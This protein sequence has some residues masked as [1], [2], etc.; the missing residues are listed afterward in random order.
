[1]ETMDKRAVI[2][3]L[4][5]IYKYKDLISKSDRDVIKAIIYKGDEKAI[6]FHE[7]F[8]NLVA[9]E[10]D[11][12]LNKISF[13]ELKDILIIEMRQYIESN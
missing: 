7:D 1:M 5:E 2:F 10:I 3:E 9:S 4:D 6:K 8:R 12:S 13:T 11:H